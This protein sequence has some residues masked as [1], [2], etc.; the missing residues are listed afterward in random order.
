LFILIFIRTWQYDSENILP[1]VGIFEERILIIII[2]N[3]SSV[4][5]IIHQRWFLDKKN[6]SLFYI[7]SFVDDVPTTST[8]FRFSGVIIHF[9]H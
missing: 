6:S 2:I 9:R 3:A 8:S 4:G 7:V 5:I 1:R